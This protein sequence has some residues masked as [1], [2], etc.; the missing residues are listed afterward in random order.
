M[1]NNF[2]YLSEQ[3]SV[4]FQPTNYFL[5]SINYAFILN[6]KPDNYILYLYIINNST[7]AIDNG[8]HDTTSDAYLDSNPLF[9]ISP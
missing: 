5:C 7:T 6:F 9:S 8:I 4:S 3:P 1:N 2:S